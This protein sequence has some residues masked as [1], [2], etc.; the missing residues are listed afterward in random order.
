[1]AKVCI[2]NVEKNLSEA[3][4]EAIEKIDRK[5]I[6]HG[7]RVLLKPNLVEPADP[8]SGQITTPRIVEA[9]ASYCLECGAG[10]VIIG[11][12]P[13]YYQPEPWL[14]ECFTR[15][16]ISDV[17]RRL[18]LK[19][20]LF[21]EHEYRTFKSIPGCIA[22]DFRVTEYAFNCD[23]FINLPVLKTHW[24]CRVTLAMK[25]LKGCLKRED[26]PLFHRLDINRAI[27]EL[28]KVVKPTLNII[29]GTPKAV[30]RQM[31]S[32]FSPWREA[33]GGLIIASTDIVAADAVG[34]ALMGI[35][36]KSVSTINLGKAA[37][38]GE[39]D[40]TRIDIAGEELRRLKFKPHIPEDELKETFPG[41]KVIG[42][43]RACSGCL[44]PL[45]SDLVTLS[46]RG[47]K[48]KAAI[49]VYI[50]QK[51]DRELLK[52]HLIIGDCA[53]IRGRAN[54]IKGCPPDRGEILNSLNS[55][56]ASASRSKPNGE[57]K[58]K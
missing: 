39:G 37:G 23:K 57:P 16:G 31:G 52:M 36:P 42:A 54:S 38:L 9:V 46:D 48:S 45:V 19:W 53:Y 24:L 20:V 55:L 5:A 56:L 4:A 50:G 58:E 29:D 43:A 34:S 2:A 13:G 47:V 8:E 14:T 27:V 22:R 12:G 28:G 11:E 51:P 44:I 3:L 49:G 33:N 35:D 18:G 17:A 30:T 6:S 7:D 32:G 15:T 26:K 21:D 40:L 41:L 1:M 25:N 10:E